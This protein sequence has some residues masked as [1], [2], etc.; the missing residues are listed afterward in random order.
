[1]LYNLNTLGGFISQRAPDGAI[2]VAIGDH[3]PPAAISGEDADW[4]IP[5]HVFGRDATL[6]SPFERAGFT[7][8]TLPEGASVGRVDEITSLILEA[9]EKPLPNS[10]IA[11]VE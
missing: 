11:G 5:I 9:L 3:Q 4:D 7:A 2:I 10:R 8:G 1:M 6:L